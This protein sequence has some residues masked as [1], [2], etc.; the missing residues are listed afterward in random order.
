MQAYQA[1]NS[2]IAWMLLR[3]GPV[4]AHKVQFLSVR[5]QFYIEV[6]N[7]SSLQSRKRASVSAL[8]EASSQDV[9][10]SIFPFP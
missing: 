7:D 4:V 6:S 2:C 5:S 9:A 1:V 10:K 8:A 3:E